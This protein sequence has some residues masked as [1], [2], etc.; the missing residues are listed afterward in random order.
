MDHHVEHDER[1]GGRRTLQEGHGGRVVEHR[2][3][4]GGGEHWVAHPQ[5]VVGPEHFG[6]VNEHEGN[7]GRKAA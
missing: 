7:L 1:K 5:G 2:V 4:A 3:V 6:R